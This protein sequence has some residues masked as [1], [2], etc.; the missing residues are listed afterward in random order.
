MS[1]WV[2]LARVSPDLLGQIIKKPALL[3]AMLFE[4]EDPKIEGFDQDGDV[5]GEDYR[6][7]FVPYFEHLAEAAGDDPDDFDSSE[8]V[9]KDPIYRGISGDEEIDYDFCY[10]PAMYNTP[11][12]V[13][14]IA[15]SWEGD[16]SKKD[17]ADTERMDVALYLFY[18]EAAEQGRAI[19]CGI[20]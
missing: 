15:N 11:G 16:F 4:D 12:V 10:G 9:Q 19:I 3:D 7:M 8:S 20:S 14:E 1:M 2:N 13:Q 18:K 6:H 17:L 5:F